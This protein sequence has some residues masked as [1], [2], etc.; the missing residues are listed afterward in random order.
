M[1]SV[2]E[3]YF[4]REAKAIL[5]QDDKI[6]T[7]GYFRS[8]VARYGAASIVSVVKAKGYFLAKT[9]SNLLVIE[10]RAPAFRKPLMENNRSYVIPL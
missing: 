7:F 3:E 4:I 9:H 2:E 6:V 1:A 10:T 5:G 8:E